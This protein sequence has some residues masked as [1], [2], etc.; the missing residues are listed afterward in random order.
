MTPLDLFELWAPRQSLWARWAKP[1]LFAELPPGLAPS[2]Q[3]IDVP[4]LDVQNDAQ[5]AI[6]VDLPGIEAVRIGIALAR[7]GYQTVPLFNAAVGPS[8]V[9]SAVSLIN[10]QPLVQMLADS[11]PVL[12]SLT[13][14]PEAPPAFL[15]DSRRQSPETTIVPGKFDNRWLVFPQDFPSAAFLKTHQIQQVIVFQSAPVPAADL[16]HVLLRWQETGIGV[17]VYNPAGNQQPQLVRVQPP[18]RFKSLCYTTLAAMGL[19]RNSAGGFGSMI[20]Q[21][22][23]G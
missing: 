20:P 21:P 1:A 2:N 5:T 17:F 22:S 23:S 11:A 15:L 13:L 19:R 18:S 10:M 12:S 4:K 9:L 6:V 3:P 8:A 14:P 16:S 7:D